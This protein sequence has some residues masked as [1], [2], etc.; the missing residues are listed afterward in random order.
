MFGGAPFGSESF[1]DAGVPPGGSGPITGSVTGAG[2]I[3]SDE[4]FGTPSVGAD[5]TFS[6]GAAGDIASGE[7]FGSPTVTP[8]TS[9]GGTGGCDADAIAEILLRV[10]ELHRVHGLEAGATLT[11][12]ATRREA[13]SIVQTINESNGTVSVSRN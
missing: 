3:A 9:A 11:V 2:A 13:G 10:R 6:L 12:T 8:T 1:G 4:A 7:A 5:G